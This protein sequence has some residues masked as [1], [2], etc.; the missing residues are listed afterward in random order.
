MNDTEY[1]PLKIS[2]WIVSLIL[3]IIPLVNIIMLIVWAAS[4][5]THPSKKSFAQAYLI[6]IGVVFVLGFAAALI[7]PLFAH[8]TR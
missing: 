1:K 5:S 7:L 4:S 6:I 8:S 2:D 3:L